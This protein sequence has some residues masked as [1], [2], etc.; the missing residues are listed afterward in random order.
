MF[1]LRLL[2]GLFLER[3]GE[4]VTGRAAQKRRLALLAL[5]AT[6]PSRT[7][8]R[9]KLIGQLWPE[10]DTEQARHLLSVALYE[11]RKALGEELVVSRGDD[12]CLEGEELRT[13]VEELEAVV[14][15]DPERAVEL[16]AGPFL[17][18]FY[19]S[20]APEFERWAEGE[21]DRLARRHQEALETLAERRSAAG[22]PRGAVDSWRR[23]AAL[24]PYNS[25]VATQLVRALAASGDRAA[26]LQHVRIHEIMLREEFGA[27]PDP[28]LLALATRLRDEPTRDL[29]VPPAG[30]PAF[31]K[32]AEAEVV[33]EAPNGSAP[34]EAGSESGKEAVGAGVGVASLPPPGDPPEARQRDR[35]HTHRRTRWAATGAALLIGGA[36]LWVATSNDWSV[37][38]GRDP[39]T[40][41]LLPFSSARE[42]E[43][44]GDGLAEEII[45]ALA[46]V[47]GIEVAA[48]TSTQALK[49]RQVDVREAGETL[50]VESVLEGSVR[51]EGNRVR[52]SA[53]LV[54]VES[55]TA[56]WGHIYERELVDLFTI[57]RDIAREVVTALKGRL[58]TADTTSLS[59]ART[60]DPVAWDLYQRG[61]LHWSRRSGEGFRRALG[62]FQQAAA[63]DPGYSLAYTGIANVY[64]LLGAY[65]YGV[66]PPLQAIPEAKLALSKALALDPRSAEAHAA[67]G[68]VLYNYDWDWAGAEREFELAEELDPRYAQ[69]YHWHALAL[70]TSGRRDAALRSVRMARELEPLS[71]VIATA[72]ARV[73]YFA[74]DFP[75]AVREYR[76]ALEMD[77]SFVPGHLGLG[78]TYVQIGSPRAAIGEYQ[79]AAR[80]LG[81][82][83]PVAQ[84]LLAHAQA[85]SGQRDQARATLVRLTAESASRYIP[86]E[87]LALIH[88]GLGEK[89]RALDWLEV[90]YRQRSG[91]LAFLSVEPLLEPLRAEPRFQQLARRVGPASTDD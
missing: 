4:V 25:R 76:R 49:G 57:Q 64:S 37:L 12:V 78:L 39:A 38:P 20:E 87:Y 23:L 91:A 58:L 90:A 77:S 79:V 17:D 88:L 14:R 83:Q 33:L 29:L 31:V 75:E 46:G 32:G 11:L 71:P 6:A 81:A 35:P 21:R 44:I 7:M 47:E 2:G 54:D 70:V 56:R 89:D 62:F 82:P 80:L 67:L 68:N 27:E 43:H 22:D 63:Q 26:A 40:I 59:P 18:G 55:G 36:G 1:T 42:N 51:R 84:A 10:S 48:L 69:A 41:G 34:V 72:R 86:A 30:V 65:D 73:L 24:D 60:P 61:R 74:G 45:N 3:D 8:S 15:E 19:L 5:L 28:E 50:A 52:I 9:D 16:Y 66:L 13:D 53:R 85:L